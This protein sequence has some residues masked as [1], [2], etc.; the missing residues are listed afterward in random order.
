MKI[1]YY[2]GSFDPI[3]NGHISLCNYLIEQKIVDEVWIVPCHASYYGKKYADDVH[4]IEMCNITVTA[5]NNPQIKVCTVEID[6]KLTGESFDIMS[7]LIKKY[8]DHQLH[9]VIGFDNAV[10]IVTWTNWDKLVSLLPFIIFP[11]K[12]YGIASNLWFLEKPHIFMK[13]YDANEI[14]SSQFKLDIVK[15]KTCE[16]VHKLVLDYIFINKLYNNT[17]DDNP[18]LR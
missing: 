1:A 18:T 2:G 7:D 14:S 17:V 12:G 3:T 5:N 8:S 11:R 16:I 4:R 10:K 13:D 9:F 15:H 6:N